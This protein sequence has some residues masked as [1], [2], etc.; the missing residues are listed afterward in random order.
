M[1]GAGEAFVRMTMVAMEDTI[2]AFICSVL[3]VCSL[4]SRDDG[5][6]TLPAVH[7]QNIITFFL[8]QMGNQR[9][10]KIGWFSQVHIVSTRYKWCIAAETGQ[11]PMTRDCSHQQHS[12]SKPK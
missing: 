8:V 9:L 12:A 1:V 2:P 11:R 5:L 4:S 3:S 10:E 7:S 6:H